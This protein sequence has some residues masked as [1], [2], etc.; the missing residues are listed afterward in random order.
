MM[1]ELTSDNFLDFI[2]SP[3]EKD[4]LAIVDFKAAWCGPCK[5]LLNALEP[6]A[7][8]LAAEGKVKIGTIDVDAQEELQ[9]AFNIRGLPTVIM[10]RGG[11]VVTELRKGVTLQ[12][13]QNSVKLFTTDAED[14][15]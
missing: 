13:V 7:A 1:T 4:E 6:Y 12:T 9:K 5:T 3:K 14:E 10:F 15:F 8:E 11:N 2:A